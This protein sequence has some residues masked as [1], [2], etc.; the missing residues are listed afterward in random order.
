MLR[1]SVTVGRSDMLWFSVTLV[2]LDV[3]DFRNVG[4]TGFRNGVLRIFV[5]GF[6]FFYSSALRGVLERR[7]IPFHEI[8]GGRVFHIAAL[9][10]PP[11]RGLSLAVNAKA[12]AL[13][14]NDKA[15]LLKF[16]EPASN[17]VKA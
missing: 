15:E 14:L 11:V 5:T 16:T 10:Q 12:A 13:R 1:F 8:T 7:P 6:C 2:P 17:L 4:V 3:T 9:R